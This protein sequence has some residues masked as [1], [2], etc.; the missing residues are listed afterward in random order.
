MSSPQATPPRTY[1]QGFY[2]TFSLTAWSRGGRPWPHWGG[3]LET[4]TPRPQPRPTESQSH[5][6]T[7]SGW[8]RVQ[9][10][11][12]LGCVGAARGHPGAS[13]CLGLWE[14]AQ[15]LQPQVKERPQGLQQVKC[16]L[17]LSM[18]PHS[19]LLWGLLN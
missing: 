2:T 10:G 18:C 11:G 7:L 12:S 6:T 5:L 14:P 8:F 16:V 13:G 1:F 3:L 19:N 17:R 9:S 4:L 15:H